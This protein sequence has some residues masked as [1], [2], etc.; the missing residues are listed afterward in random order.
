MDKMNIA[1]VGATGIVGQTFI[2]LLESRN[3]PFKKLKLF[4]SPKN[5]GKKISVKEQ[6]WFIQNLQ[7]ECF[8]NVDIA[9]FSAGG[10]ISRKWAD[11]AVRSGAFV[12]DNSS[13]FRMQTNIPLVVP[14]INGHLIKNKK[15]GIIA[16]PN[17][18]TI[19][20]ALVLQPLQQA[21]GLE[22]VIVSSYQSLSGAGLEALNKLKQ[23]SITVL[24]KETHL[25]PAPAEQY[26]FNCI[27]QIGAID[28][29]GFSTEENK[30]MNET[31]KILNLP[32]L[33]ISATAVRVPCFNGHGES[34]WIT[35]KKPADSLESILKIVDDQ[36]GVTVLQKEALPNQIFID[37]KEDVYVGRIRPV[38]N[39][40]NK[41]WI[42]W[43]CG[44]NLKKGAALNGLQIAGKLLNTCKSLKN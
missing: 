2:K 35:L 6:D 28:E 1:I 19:Q 7:P 38:P 24:N 43:I 20:L 29:N 34:V 10:I 16:N 3:F 31:R 4:A 12:I 9:F 36:D 26:A 30:L 42:T 5:T 39:S 11:E 37:G 18:S 14:E 17:C 32:E 22:T 40:H 44:D 8:K 33:K 21:F 41:A 23:E 13:A 25:L 15:P 27:P